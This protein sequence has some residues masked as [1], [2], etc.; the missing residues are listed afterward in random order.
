MKAGR[1]RGSK[2]RDPIIHHL[3]TH[4]GELKPTRGE[5][6]RAVEAPNENSIRPVIEDLIKEKIVN[7]PERKKNRTI[8]GP[9]R[10]I[11]RGLVWVYSLNTDLFYDIV[12]LYF[13]W[14]GTRAIDRSQQIRQAEFLASDFASRMFRGSDLDCLLARAFMKWMTVWDVD[15]LRLIRNWVGSREVRNKIETFMRQNRLRWKLDG[16]W[17]DFARYLLQILDW[18]CE[19]KSKKTEAVRAWENKLEKIATDKEEQEILRIAYD[20][21]LNWTDGREKLKTGAYLRVSPSAVRFLTNM[22][23]GSGISPAALLF[24]LHRLA[25]GLTDIPQTVEDL[26]A[27][28]G[29]MRTEYRRFIKRVLFISLGADLMYNSEAIAKARGIKP[30]LLDDLDIPGL[31][32][33]VC[34]KDVHSPKR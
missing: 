25:K 31:V 23:E 1:P 2:Y 10:T 29:R 30:D 15:H 3:V 16:N 21:L 28:R 13:P 34:L 6:A 26:D 7:K 24:D 32:D 27:F 9:E 4:T 8:E 20:L 14:K 5:I 18:I 17:D 11:V 22:D 19:I 12:N 33:E